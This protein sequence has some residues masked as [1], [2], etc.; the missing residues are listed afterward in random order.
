MEG[1]N[2][3][4]SCALLRLCIYIIMHVTSYVCKTYIHLYLI[5]NLEI[6]IAN[7]IHLLHKDLQM[8]DV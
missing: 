5:V 4:V 8:A 7:K 2:F 6:C 1:F 3:D